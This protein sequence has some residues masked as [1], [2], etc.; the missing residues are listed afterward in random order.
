MASKLKSTTSPLHILSDTGAPEG[1]TDYTTVVLIHGFAWHSERLQRYNSANWLDTTPPRCQSDTPTG[2]FT[3][4]LPLA[5]AHN[6]RVVLL[7]RRDY[8]GSTPYTAAELSD[9]RTAADESTDSSAA[10]TV[11]LQFLAAR[12][13]E[14]YD[15]LDAFVHEHDIPPARAEEDAGGIVLV[16]WSFGT[17][18]TTA[19]LAHVASFSGGTP[20]SLGKYVRRVIFHDTPYHVL[21]FPPIPNPYNPLSDPTLAPEAA[22]LA[23]SNW[24]SGYYGHRLSSPEPDGAEAQSV[25]VQRLEARHPL[26]HPPPTLST[27]SDAERAA[28]L[29]PVPGGP[30]GSDSLILVAAIRL[31]IFGLLRDQALLLPDRALGE[32][33]ND[34]GRAGGE[35]QGQ[36]WYGVEVRYMWCDHSVWEMPWGVWNMRARIQEDRKARKTM[37]NFRFLRLRGANHFVHWDEPERA[38]RAFLAPTSAEEM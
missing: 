22:P 15:L 35:K 13:R 30:G 1:S 26:A 27:L 23:F 18:L 33:D 17:C 19:F 4:L 7:N 25:F 38:L 10:K 32:E 31:G 20:S 11:L 34:K 12:A 14:L 24:V 37:R 36:A 8:P 5:P 9:L 29:Y 28:S 16:G 6:A 21:G 2:I 3:K